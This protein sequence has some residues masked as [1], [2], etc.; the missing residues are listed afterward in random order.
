MLWSP[1]R[2]RR[3]SR[4]KLIKRVLIVIILPGRQNTLVVFNCSCLTTA[5]VVPCTCSDLVV[6]F[7]CR[8]SKRVHG[9]K[10]VFGGFGLGML[11][12]CGRSATCGLV[13]GCSNC[14]R[15]EISA[16]KLRFG[17]SKMSLKCFQT[18]LA[19]LHGEPA[20]KEFHLI[21]AE[22]HLIRGLLLFAL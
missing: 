22:N 20:S 16:R 10:A 4:T 13:A 1:E 15:N 8:Y 7:P 2:F 12:I 3:P 11:R 9:P 18:H 17:I 21:R 14:L 5:D 6:T 19:G